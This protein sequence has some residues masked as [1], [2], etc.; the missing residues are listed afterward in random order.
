MPDFT[1]QEKNLMLIYCTPGDSRRELLAT[2]RQMKAQLTD[3]DI[4]G[5]EC[6][7]CHCIGNICLAFLKKEY[8]DEPLSAAQR[9]FFFR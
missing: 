7:D 9:F 4:L 1:V 5:R 2:L 3:E 8:D 6:L